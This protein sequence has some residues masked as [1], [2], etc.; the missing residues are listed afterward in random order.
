MAAPRLETRLTDLNSRPGQTTLSNFT[1]GRFITDESENL[2]KRRIRFN[3][4]ALCDAAARASGARKCVAITK[5]P[6]G[7]FN[8]AYLLRMD[9]G[10]QV[11]AK[12]PNPNAG[13]PRLTTASEVAS[14][15]FFRRVTGTPV[16]RVLD[17]SAD[18]GNPVGSEYIIMEKM[19]GVVLSSVWS[20]LSLDA[21]KRVVAKLLKHHKAWADVTF[22][23]YGSLY[24]PQD[25]GLKE[26]EHSGVLYTQG[27]EDIRNIDY[28]VGPAVGREWTSEGKNSLVA[29]RGPFGSVLEYKLAA[30]ERERQAIVNANES[31]P[32]QAG[33]ICGPDPF[34]QST[35]D[36]KFKALQEY[37][38]LLQHPD[39]V[40]PA[41]RQDA[42]KGHI[43]H[44]DLH[45]ENIFV[46]PNDYTTITGIVDWQSAQIAPLIDQCLDPHLFAYGGLD[47]GYD[48]VSM[49][50]PGSMNTWNT[51]ARS[52][53]V[54]KALM[55][56]WRA[57]VKREIPRQHSALAFKQTTVGHILHLARHLLGP[58]EAHLAVWIK[59]LRE[60]W[61]SARPGA[62]FPV[63]FAPLRLQEIA[64]DVK[65][66]GFSIDATS[67][68]RKRL[69]SRLGE[70]LWPDT[71]IIR[72]DK[73]EHVKQALGVLKKEVM[74]RY[75]P[76]DA[77][78]AAR[79]DR[80]AFEREWPF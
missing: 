60:D 12:L 27:G 57:G 59:F 24:F 14:M 50:L 18:A 11:V 37:A 22:E 5:Y 68:L 39:I 74:D 8:K 80:E 73:Y 25:L 66:A 77:D 34:Y 30:L 40:F 79:K 13:I 26:G 16:P 31:F 38:A 45:S 1:R 72:A 47:V 62:P 33:M 53:F 15:D 49:M 2:A 58:S 61:Q 63:P 19:E 36:K 43:W 69:A 41:E 64:T 75:F 17:Y 56:S 7:M 67:D 10:R 71:G 32:R 46:D 28:V 52:A 54:D 44:N 42:F 29:N 70:D 9:D 3:L 48:T 20:K 51:G 23:Q 65:R 78:S 21:K 35:A 55:A 6:E 4:E 76:L